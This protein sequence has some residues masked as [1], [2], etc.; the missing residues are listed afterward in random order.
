MWESGQVRTSTTNK[1]RRPQS[2]HDLP[3]CSSHTAEC[4]EFSHRLPHSLARASLVI[5]LPT[6]RCSRRAELP[7]TAN[8]EWRARCR[9]A[10][11]PTDH[12][13]QAHSEAV[14]VVCSAEGEQDDRMLTVYVTALHDRHLTRT[15]WLGASV[16]AHECGPCWC[17]VVLTRSLPPPLRVRLRR[18]RRPRA[19]ARRVPSPSETDAPC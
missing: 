11:T 1:P 8:S 14:R 12:S 3:Q 6:W 16:C 13:L 15:A 5:G 4:N 10:R 19:S 9:Y 18:A 2:G 7:A 17:G